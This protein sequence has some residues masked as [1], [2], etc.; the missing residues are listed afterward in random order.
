MK[1][2]HIENEWTTRK[3]RGEIADKYKSDFHTQIEEAAMI[4][5]HPF[6][7]S[8][9]FIKGKDLLSLNLLPR[10]QEFKDRLVPF[11]KTENKHFVSYRWLE[12]SHPDPN[13]LQLKL[14]KQVIKPDEYY[15]I[16]FSCLPQSPNTYEDKEFLSEGLK[17][18]PSLIFETD[19]VILRRPDDE[20]LSR[21]W[22]FFEVLASTVIGK[23][24]SRVCEDSVDA[25]SIEIAERTVLE[26]TF[27]ESSL[28]RDLKVT[29][30][31]DLAPIRKMTETTVMFFELNLLMHYL[32][33]GQ[34]I[35]DQRLFFGEDPYYLF[36]TCD[37]SQV[38]S[39]VF[40]KAR[41]HKMPISDLGKSESND[42]FFINLAE[43]EKFS[44]N[45]NPNTLLKKV[46]MDQGK[47]SW[48]IIRRDTPLHSNLL[49]AH[50]LFYFL[51]SLI[52]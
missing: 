36:A 39:W 6:V 40:E 45:I 47:Q 2:Q 16:D 20:Y 46:T 43:K 28:P 13:G 9:Y 18:L 11:P 51:T 4:Q 31:E 15:W 23:G 21:A 1:K 22:C 32:S 37:F 33:L 24:V 38:T 52:K 3:E 34:Q 42:N 50:N 14:L 27:S 30:E 49:S 7:K 29:N 25:I 17:R 12:K 48:F 19:V 8:F 41:E 10:F 5:E 35:S 44:H 26:Q